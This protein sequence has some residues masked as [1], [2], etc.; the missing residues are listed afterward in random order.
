MSASRAA[1]FDFDGTIANSFDELAEVYDRVALEL[2]LRRLSPADFETF[3]DMTPLEVMHAAGIPVRKI[4]RLM[5]AMRSGMRERT[6][7]L[8][9][10]AGMPGVIRALAAQGCRCGIL[11]SNS[12]ENV[13][14]FLERHDLPMFDLFSCGAT[15]LGKAARLRKLIRQLALPA[16][17]IFYIGDEVRDVEAAN[18][19]GIQSIGVSWGLASRT[20]L[21]AARASHIADSPDQLIDCILQSRVSL[22]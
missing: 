22:A 16:R 2:G 9:P 14:C 17:N 21:R 12:L 20:A 13:R 4:P 10:F 7:N 11:S 18:E 19:V 6:K 1:I 3:R 15:F 5:T 8:R